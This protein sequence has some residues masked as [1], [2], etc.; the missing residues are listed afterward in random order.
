M[1]GS[2][3]AVSNKKPLFKKIN[4]NKMSIEIVSRR[5]YFNVKFYFKIIEINILFTKIWFY[6]KKVL[7]LLV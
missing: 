1:G 7:P 3:E 4:K 2:K 5:S 6:K